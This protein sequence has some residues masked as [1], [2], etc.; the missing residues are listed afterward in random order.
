MLVTQNGRPAGVVLSPAEFDLLVE[1]ERLVAD[2]A[3]G[4]ADLEAGR[5]HSL[6]DVRRELARRRGTG[7]KR[8]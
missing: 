2:V 6:D 4:I 8:R 7:R 5:T 1:R 3:A